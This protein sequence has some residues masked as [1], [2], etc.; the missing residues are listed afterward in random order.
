MGLY[1]QSPDGK[2]SVALTQ[3]QCDAL[4]PLLNDSVTKRFSKSKFNQACLDALEK[5]G[6]PATFPAD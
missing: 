1:V 4:V 2:R 5:A 3:E 6:M